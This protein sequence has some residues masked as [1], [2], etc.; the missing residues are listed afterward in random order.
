MGRGPLKG[1]LSRPKVKTTSSKQHADHWRL[2]TRSILLGL[3]NFCCLP[4]R[5]GGSPNVLES[6]SPDQ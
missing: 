5:A 3:S 1:A 2:Q 4:G 6:G